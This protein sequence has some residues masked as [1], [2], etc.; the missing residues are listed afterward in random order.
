MKVRVPW[1]RTKRGSSIGKARPS[2]M[3]SP[4]SPCSGESTVTFS[5][6]SGSE[7]GVGH[8]Q[9]R[10]D[11]EGDGEEVIALDRVIAVEEVPVVEVPVRA[12]IGDRLGGLVDGEI[13]AL[14][15]RHAGSSRFADAS[16]VS[17]SSLQAAKVNDDNLTRQP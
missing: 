7:R 17:V 6:W 9:V 12:R 8:V 4:F 1:R 11:P 3:T 13:V 15:K 16:H 2:K 14:G 5:F 10:I